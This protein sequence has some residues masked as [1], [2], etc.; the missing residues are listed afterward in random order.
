MAPQTIGIEIAGA[1]QPL[2]LEVVPGLL[3]QGYTLYH[4][5]DYGQGRVPRSRRVVDITGVVID[6]GLLPVINSKYGRWYVADTYFENNPGQFQTKLKITFLSRWTSTPIDPGYQRIDLPAKEN[7]REKKMSDLDAAM[8]RTSA[9]LAASTIE[10]RKALDALPDKKKT[11]AYDK[12]LEGYKRDNKSAER[13]EVSR[14]TARKVWNTI[15]V[16][17]T[18]GALAGYMLKAWELF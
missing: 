14:T 4:E 17:A 9:D 7:V 16:L 3:I 6:H 5:T 8:K 2:G 15:T 18:L 12:R 1:K 13:H 11:N 10:C